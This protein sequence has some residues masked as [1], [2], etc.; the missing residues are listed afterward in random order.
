MQHLVDLVRHT[1]DCHSTCLADLHE[2]LSWLNIKI[3]SIEIGRRH[4]EVVRREE[5]RRSEA[6]PAECTRSRC[7][8]KPSKE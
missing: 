1:V 6:P 8:S 5:A 2:R 7:R 4:D 3:R